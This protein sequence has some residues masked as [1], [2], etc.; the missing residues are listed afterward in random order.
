V[1]A[2]VL[3]FVLVLIVENKAVLIEKAHD[4]CL[5]ARAP[6]KVDDDVEEPVL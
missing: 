2:C 5:P 1:N 3:K 4:G 6:Q